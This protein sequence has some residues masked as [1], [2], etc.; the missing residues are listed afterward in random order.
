[1]QT[2]IATPSDTSSEVS[3]GS[4]AEVPDEPLPTVVAGGLDFIDKIASVLQPS[5]SQSSTDLLSLIGANPLLTITVDDI[6]YH[7]NPNWTV[8]EMMTKVERNMG[9]KLKGLK[10]AG[11]LMDHDKTLASYN[12]QSRSSLRTVPATMHV[13]MKNLEGNTIT[14]KLMPHDTIAVVKVLV[15]QLEGVPREEQQ[16]VFAG[17]LMK[18]DYVLIEK[19]IKHE[20]NICLTSGL[21]GAG[22]RAK[23]VEADDSNE[24]IFI[25]LDDTRRDLDNLMIILRTHNS[26]V[27]KEVIKQAEK[28][29]DLLKEHEE[30]T[31]L[32]VFKTLDKKPLKTLTSFNS[33]NYAARLQ[34]ISKVLF[35]DLYETMDKANKDMKLAEQTIQ[36][37]TSLAL[38]VSYNQT[39]FISWQKINDDILEAI[40]T[41]SSA[42]KKECVV[43]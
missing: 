11:A 12:I 20:S 29:M 8:F 14:L 39:G 25:Q 40:S 9:F 36:A 4:E 16:I 19:G 31:M 1:L 3:S 43:S 10:F 38:N 24:D 42:S 17:H 15:Q 7:V 5:T 26:N 34:A 23:V 30:E 22:K 28:S 21:A 41:S 6:D 27:S 37:L 13:Y 32:T 2:S 18:D 33:K 35:P